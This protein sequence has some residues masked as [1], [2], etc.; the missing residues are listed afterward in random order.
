[1]NNNDKIQQIQFMENNLQN[2][3][4]QKQAFQMELSESQSAIKEI[5]NSEG[6]IFKIIGQLMIKTDKQKTKEELLNKERILELRIRTIEKQEDS[7]MEKLENLRKEV[8]KQ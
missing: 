1:M 4:M 7:L 2:L 5:E 8:T 6:E 3:F